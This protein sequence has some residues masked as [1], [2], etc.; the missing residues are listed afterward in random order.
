[1]VQ[2]EIGDCFAKAEKFLEEGKKVIFSGTPCQLS[3]LRAYLG[4][5]RDLLLCV[6]FI[7]HGV[8]SPGV[9][10]SSWRHIEKRVG[11][12]LIGYTFRNRLERLGNWRDFVCCYE[13]EDGQRLWEPADP[14][15]RFFLAQLCLRA[16]CGENCKFRNRNRLSD[17]TI[18]DFKGKF[19][20]FPRM[21][22]HR[23][24]STIIVNTKKGDAVCRTLTTAMRVL[25]CSMNDVERFNPLFFRSTRGNLDRGWF[26]KVFQAGKTFEDLEKQ[27]LVPQPAWK[28]HFGPVK[29]FLIPF[30][31]R[32]AIRISID[33]LRKMGEFRGDKLV[34]L[35]NFMSKSFRRN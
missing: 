9:F 8:G 19:Q 12:K 18:A 31:L 6:D 29:D 11:K 34:R 3:G 13:F 7:C 32:R 2:S 17:I 24:Y 25:P 5:E 26:F 10:A 28:K 4:K 20:V 16:S 22:D 15:Q 1:M 14:Y 30:H 33:A 23:N 21:M 27:F 35:K